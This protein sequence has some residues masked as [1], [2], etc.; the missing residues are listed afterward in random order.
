MSSATSSEAACGSGAPYSFRLLDCF[1]PDGPLAA[2]LEGFAPRDPQTEM[3]ERVAATIEANAVLVC[4]A[5]TGTGKTLAYL[6]PMLLSG[7]RGIL[8]TATKTLQDQLYFRDIP[9][10]LEALKVSLDVAMLKGRA[11]YLCLLRLESALDPAREDVLARV[12]RWSETT[13]SGD[14]DELQALDEDFSLRVQITSTTENC[15]GQQCAFYEDCFVVRARRNAAAADLA[16]V[17]HHLLFA[18]MVLK[19]TGFADLLPT[20]QVVVI[21]EAHQIPDIASLFFGESVSSRQLSDFIRDCGSAVREEAHDAP[22]LLDALVE[23]DS[24][25]ERLRRELSGNAERRVA[26]EFGRRAGL[27]QDQ[28]GKIGTQLIA[29][30]EQLAFMSERGTA[31][32]KAAE[33]AAALAAS[34]ALFSLADENQLS[35]QW[36][37]SSSRGFQLH[38]TPISIAD[39]FA[40]QISESG[41]SW[42]L[43]SAT[44]AVD[45]HFEHFKRRL[46][47]DTAD[48][49]IW[50]S[51]FDYKNRSL[52]YL[53]ALNKEPNE[54]GFHEQLIDAVVPVLE[55]TEGHAFLL[56]TS[57]RGLQIAAEHLAGKIDYPLLIQG[58]APR[59]ILLDRFANLP[60]AVLLGTATFWE[61][62]DVRGEQLRCVIIDKL[63]FAV[64]NDPVVKARIKA[65][66]AGGESG[67][68]HYQIP[69]A[70]MQLKQGAGRL[71]RDELDYGVLVLADPRITK[72]SYGRAFIN[73]LPAMPQTSQF[74]D[75]D[76]FFSQFSPSP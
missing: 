7:R 10:A 70:V 30:G 73:S 29:L 64:P 66:E 20:A 49:A 62:V 14:L 9:V 18:D 42:I 60:H 57:H 8:S 52:M 6:L 38:N 19:E 13:V 22:E 75:V 40:Q 56:F 39:R 74:D 59:S 50:D 43:T 33:R 26:W 31:V 32:Q 45:G 1:A 15:A 25:A 3:A 54:E 24:H 44:L 47:I 48:D 28:M 65:V 4:E 58:D 51:P 61:G 12:R 35:V 37:Q 41:C 16:V 11:N 68:V 55:R 5:G 72:R 67:F 46:G 53:P 34:W 63:P 69:E 21:D 2:V 23:L 27:Q 76:R 71:I 17:N 36:L